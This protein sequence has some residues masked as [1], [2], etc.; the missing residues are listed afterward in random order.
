MLEGA[1]IPGDFPLGTTVSA[2]PSKYAVSAGDQVKIAV[3]SSAHG[4]TTLIAPPG[5]TVNGT[6]VTVPAD[7]KPGKV[8]IGVVINGRPAT[9][10][11]VEVVPALSG[12]QQPLPQV[13]QF[14]NWARSVGHP[15]FVN[16][17]PP[18]LTL[19]S[20]GSRD[21]DITVSN[22]GNVPRDGT[23]SLA[24]PPGFDAGPGRPF[25]QIAPGASTT[26]RFLVRNTDPALA[27]G[28]QGGDYRYTINVPGD[29]SSAAL[30]LV[31]ATTIPQATTTPTVDAT[32]GSGEYP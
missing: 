13:A 4:R 17:V 20:G 12:R 24:M 5:W 9:E 25:P 32:A 11:L 27:T 16:N 19:P 1:V 18:V 23:V 30:E 29:T 8:R 28:Q 31:P 26:V 6:T 10:A 2:Q 21:V 7:A 22:Q 3:T 15:E 14:Q